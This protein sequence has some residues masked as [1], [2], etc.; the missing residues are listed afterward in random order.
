MSII[1]F[2]IRNCISLRVSKPSKSEIEMYETKYIS[3][4]VENIMLRVCVY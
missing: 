1:I 3:I 4:L 2:A